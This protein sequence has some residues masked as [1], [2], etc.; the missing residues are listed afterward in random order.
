LT[1]PVIQAARSIIVL[2]VGA[3][4]NGPLERAWEIGGS[5]K[6]TPARIIR[7]GRGTIAWIIDRAAGGLSA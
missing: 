3:A 2:A 5:V 7:G 1:V 6:D 4:K